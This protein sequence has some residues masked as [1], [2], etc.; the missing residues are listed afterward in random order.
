MLLSSLSS[1]L[2][3]S[4][5]FT[6]SCPRLRLTYSLICPPR[7]HAQQIVLQPLTSLLNKAVYG[8]ASVLPHHKVHLALLS[9]FPI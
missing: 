8:S 2:R 1:S 5:R 6:F 3:Q 4:F 7:S 9:L